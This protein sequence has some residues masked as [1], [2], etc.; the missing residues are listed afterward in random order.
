MQ[1]QVVMG[2]ASRP[3]DPLDETV[4]TASSV[5]MDKEMDKEMQDMWSG[6]NLAKDTL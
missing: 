2:P 3:R 4:Q 6:S 5:E 1:T